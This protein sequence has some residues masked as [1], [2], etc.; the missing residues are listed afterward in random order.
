M[1]S[2]HR[3]MKKLHEARKR[4]KKMTLSEKA[5]AYFLSGRKSDQIF[6][7]CLACV[8]V[9]PCLTHLETEGFS[10]FVAFE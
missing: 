3:L 2:T 10:L 9:G 8:L 1:A 7:Y 6:I 5:G 4:S